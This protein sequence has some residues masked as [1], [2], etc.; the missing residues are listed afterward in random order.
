[1]V[2]KLSSFFKFIILITTT[3]MLGYWDMVLPSGNAD[4]FRIVFG[5]IA[6]G[7][8][9]IVLCLRNKGEEFKKQTK[10][11]NKF[12]MLY[13][14][15]ILITAVLSVMWYRYD[16]KS[17]LA[18][19]TPYFFPL[20]AY[21]LIYI[22]YRDKTYEEFLR[23]IVVLVIVILM[24]K[25][26]AW[27]MYNFA[28]KTVFPNLIL[29]Y[30]DKWQRNGM[31]RVDVG[32][33]Y[34]VALSYLLGRFFIY[35]KKLA[36]ILAGGL[37]AFAV[38]VTQY[39]FLIIV[40]LLS[41]LLVFLTSSATNKSQVIRSLIFTAGVILFVALGGLDAI[42]ASFS[43]ENK[44]YG[45]SNEA[46][47]LTIEYFWSVLHDIQYVFGLGF[48]YGYSAKATSIITRSSTLSYWLED[49][50]ILGGFFTFGLLSLAIYVPLF[51]RSIKACVIQVKNR[52]EDRGFLV[53]LVSYM[54][55]CC[56]ML[57]IFDRQRLF[58]T[59]FYFSLISYIAAKNETQPQSPLIHKKHN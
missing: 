11:V 30:S 9:L 17:L 42:L 31:I 32:Y 59:A 29:K 8:A 19:I 53:A 49:I 40:V 56:I 34:G 23:I 28:G 48:L 6:V 24:I 27:A 41:A 43:V 14:P 39:R 51:Y 10:F 26:F 45:S 7:T 33:L 5:F 52:F 3:Y 47:V 35:K 37:L 46:R 20:F 18:I 57:N 1:M 12:F 21:P 44:D 58:D 54:I 15:V 55:I 38:F 50:G 25:A 16:F 22:F 13:I 4:N 36:L 2:I